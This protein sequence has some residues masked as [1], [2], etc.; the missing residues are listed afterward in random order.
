MS[1]MGIRATPSEIYYVIIDGSINEPSIILKDKLKHPL[2]YDLPQALTWYREQFSTLFD[3]YKVDSCAIKITEP[4]A[5][6]ISG[7]DNSFVVRCNI[8]G[9]IIE[10]ASSKDIRVNS[11]LI[12]KL[13]K[14]LKINIKETLRSDSFEKIK[15]WNGLNIYYREAILAGLAAFSL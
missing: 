9:V 6:R 4:I 8:E 13:S 1:L 10:L 12:N 3:G 5:M 7:A 11:Y 2:S 14:A 15:Q